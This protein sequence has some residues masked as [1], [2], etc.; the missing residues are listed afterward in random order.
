MIIA[1]D[2]SGPETGVSVRPT[3]RRFPIG[4][5]NV[6]T[7]STGYRPVC[8]YRRGRSHGRVNHVPDD[9]LD[10]LDTFGRGLL[11]GSPPRV[12]GQLRRDLRLTIRPEDGGRTAEVRYE[13]EHSQ[14]PPTLCDRGSFVTTISVTV[15]QPRHRADTWSK[16]VA[17]PGGTP[18]C[19]RCSSRE[20]SK[21]N[22][23]QQHHNIYLICGD[24]GCSHPRQRTRGA[25]GVPLDLRE[26]LSG[27]VK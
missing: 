17:S 19:A 8:F 4:V 10:Q 12:E 24:G 11:R 27:P 15:T 22:I 20:R 9:V 2:P 3:C 6:V 18:A 23:L 25:P 21:H 7:A 5:S 26:R 14:A 13:T 1:T 16:V